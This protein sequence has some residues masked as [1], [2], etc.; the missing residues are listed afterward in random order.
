[1]AFPM[2]IICSSSGAQLEICNLHLAC[3]GP[4]EARAKHTRGAEIIGN[5]T[6]ATAGLLHQESAMPCST[7]ASDAWYASIR[8][9][10]FI[11]KSIKLSMSTSYLL[12][13]LK[14]LGVNDGGV[15][16][17]LKNLPDPLPTAG[18]AS[19]STHPLEVLLAEEIIPEPLG[20]NAGWDR[21]LPG[22]LP[23]VF[24]P[25]AEPGFQHVPW[26]RRFCRQPRVA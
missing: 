12:S 3:D 1:M 21:N 20:G 17:T 5:T 11:R 15:E 8:Y 4:V 13:T 19:Q 14:F 23:P 7:A 25:R 10:Y 26:R 16:A 24:P 22:V 6:Q 2:Y 18:T 9:P